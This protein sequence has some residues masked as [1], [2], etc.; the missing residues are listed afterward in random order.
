M[1]EQPSSTASTA[2][3]DDVVKI[4]ISQYKQAVAQMRQ[5]RLQLVAASNLHRLMREKEEELMESKEEKKQLQLALHQSEMRLSSMIRL[6]AATAATSSPA[7]THVLEADCASATV[8][9]LELDVEPD[10]ETVS[11]PRQS[12]PLSSSLVKPTE[13]LPNKS[14]TLD[15]AVVTQTPVTLTASPPATLPSSASVNVCAAHVTAQTLPV[16]CTTS[17]TIPES[18][19]LVDKVLQQ[20]ARLK[21]TLR[22]LLSQKGL[23][24]STYLV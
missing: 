2:D 13:R 6:Q 3:R 17:T 18:K 9:Q 24:V 16:S 14:V 21:K 22:D 19:D 23:S 12:F 5:Q 15:S 1:A 20:N 10:G 8:L 11:P 7:A 4:P